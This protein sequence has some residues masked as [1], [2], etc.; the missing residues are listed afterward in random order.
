MDHARSPYRLSEVLYYCTSAL[1]ALL[2]LAAPGTSLRWLGLSALV[3]GQAAC[4]V[5]RRYRWQPAVY[6]IATYVLCRVAEPL[7]IPVVGKH[8]LLG[9]A[10]LPAICALSLFVARRGFSLECL[11][12]GS[13]WR[14]A[15][16]ACVFALLLL[17]LT[18]STSSSLFLP[19]WR[20]LVTAKS[21]LSV[22]LT[23][24]WFI[25][26]VGSAFALFDAL[27]RLVRGGA[28]SRRRRDFLLL[29]AIGLAAGLAYLAMYRPGLMS[30]DSSVQWRQ[31]TGALPLSDW[32]PYLHTLII[33]LLSK[34][35]PSPVVLPLLQI[36]LSALVYASWGTFLLQRGARRTYLYGLL[37]LFSVAPFHAIL[38]ITLWK[39]VLYTLALTFLTLQFA[40]IAV[41]RED[42]FA[43]PSNAVAFAVST[44]LVWSMR[45]NG[46]IVGIC[47]LSTVGA[48]L[49]L[50]LKSSP[51]RGGRGAF[52]MSAI[53]TLIL[54]AELAVL[55]V[56]PKALGVIPNQR[57]AGYT[58]FLSPL[59]A[60]AKDGV[61]STRPLDRT[62]TGTLALMESVM[63]IETWI[64]QYQKYT[65]FKY[66]VD[67]DLLFV[68]NASRLRPADVLAVYGRN[69]LK[70]PAYVVGD[71][72]NK[73][74][75]LW[76]ITDTDFQIDS[77]VYSYVKDMREYGVPAYTCVPGRRLF[78]F[79]EKYNELFFRLGIYSM[80][81]VL[82]FGY[83][84][85]KG[86]RGLMLVYI[87]LA[88]NTL[89]LLLSMPSPEYRF[90]YYLF[91][92]APFMLTFVL[93]EMHHGSPANLAPRAPAGCSDN[94]PP[95]TA[96]RFTKCI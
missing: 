18:A 3:I 16:A 63:P 33:R 9:R 43:R 70:Y 32:H 90:G 57:A 81:L 19:G 53:I 1:A 72:L 55:K 20:V 22:A 51:R 6:L 64:Q 62:D 21:L 93:V 85:I 12:G 66:L 13:G 28:P 31:A 35:Y 82:L 77:I 45:H 11:R 71:R 40:R 92:L 36:A 86:E 52:A 69:L 2:A 54:A 25:P 30:P 94:I 84:A 24:V 26:W 67:N 74:S 14:R 73:T 80:V 10:Y 8:P 42:Y 89:S 7:N 15:G 87:P 37:I 27:G 17:Y 41:G 76:S 60:L 91:E 29:F 34:A 50:C 75:I 44:A 79:L 83:I 4:G 96:R 46:F 48:C 38:N 47:A 49:A 61:Y 59:G 39:D 56:V 5:R 68:T 58:T 65:V 78:E 23:A 95:P 88:A